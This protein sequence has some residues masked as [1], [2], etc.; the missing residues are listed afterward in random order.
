MSQ[1]PI[2]ASPPDPGSSWNL[3]IRQ[4]LAIVRLEWFRTLIGRRSLP[5]WGFAGLPVLFFLIRMIAPIEDREDIAT[6][7]LAFAKIHNVLIVRL[8]VF[9]SCILVFTNVF[10]GEMVHQTLHYYF[11]AP[12]RRDV[13]VA[14]KFVAGWA[15]SSCCWS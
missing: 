1:T 2:F 7:V 15:A 13:L 9:L 4:A 11:L 10:R 5:V 3:W 6:A 14:G 8:I 12:I